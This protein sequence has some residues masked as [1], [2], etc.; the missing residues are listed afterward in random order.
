MVY[1]LYPYIT[2]KYA[3]E[4]NKIIDMPM[5][6]AMIFKKT[7]EEIPIQIRSGDII[8]GRYGYEDSIP[9]DIKSDEEMVAPEYKR[10]PELSHIAFELNKYSITASFGAGHTCLDYKTIIEKGLQYYFDIISNEAMKISLSAAE[11]YAGRFAALALK[12]AGETNITEERSRLTRIVRACMQVPMKP[13]RDFFEAV[14]SVWLVHN[15]SPISDN[16]WASVSLGR[17][18]QYLYPYYLKNREE[19]PE[20]LK[21]L[22]TLLNNYGDGACAL[23]IGGLSYEGEDLMNELS[24]LIIC[25]EKESALC[26]PI[27]AARISEKTPDKILEQLVDDNLFKIGQPTFYGEEICRKSTET[28]NIDAKTAAVFS[29]NSCMGLII[30]GFEIADMWGCKFNTHLPLELAVN[31]GKPLKGE[32]LLDLKTQPVLKLNSMDA[33]FEQYKLYFA[34]LLGYALKLNAESAEMNAALYP[35]PF[36]SAI[37]GDCT[38]T[39]KDRAI[40]ARYNN[41]TVEAMGLVNTVNAL[42]A[43]DSLVFRNKK[44]SVSEFISAAQV[45]YEGYETLRKDILH[46]EKYGMNTQYSNTIAKRM[47]VLISG[48]CMKFNFDNTRY[49]PSLH[50]LDANVSFGYNLY[51][52]FDGRQNGAPVAKNADMSGETSDISPTDMALTTASVELYRFSGG[53]PIDLHFQPED[54]KNKDSQKKIISLIRTFH[55]LGGMQLQVN[56]INTDI[57]KKA[58]ANPADYKQLI[59]RIGGYS[60]RFIDMGNH[61]KLEFIKRSDNNRI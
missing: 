28:R 20:I 41:V 1:N 60:R 57:L 30:S 59:V 49:L 54:L 43:L 6:Q 2:K 4:F 12:L 39:G 23:N 9:D 44:Y 7:V 37:T 47:I 14:Q 40:G 55:K 31:S 33:I 10:S 51:A 42:I 35:N 56:S 53:Q 48:I 15:L 17:M 22:F 13:A 29:V 61:E 32:L 3:S 24:E 21:F 52:T 5:R 58:Y 34:E 16:N 19:A 18:D 38:I 50:T 36:I 25:V 45:N 27:I 26:S 46:A 8:A 11:A